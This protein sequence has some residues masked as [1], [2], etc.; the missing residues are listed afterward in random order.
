LGFGLGR[1][2]THNLRPITT[3]DIILD[4]ISIFFLA[5]A[6]GMDAF[7]VA[8]SAGIILKKVT[9]RQF[10]RLSFHFGLF[11]FLMPV[12][13]WL[14][15]LSVQ[16]F[17]QH[18]DHWIAFVLL[19]FIGGKMIYESFQKEEEENKNDPT[20]GASLVILSIATSIDALAVG[21]SLALLRI[22]IWFPGIVIGIVAMVMTL[23]GMLIGKGAGLLFGKRVSVMGGIILLV[24]GI[25]ILIEH[26]K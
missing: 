22:S 2:K 25:K 18:Y 9:F 16:K 23:L 5:I 4:L 8:I 21:F 26:M 11:Q 15:G 24:I 13:G 3:G 20:K 1:L 19:A 17:I 10:F 6:L 12:I 14:A 7:A